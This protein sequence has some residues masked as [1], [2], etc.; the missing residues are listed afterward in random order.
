M[1]FV[2]L[3]SFLRDFY[4]ISNSSLKFKK[5]RHHDIEYLFPFIKK[6]PINIVTMEEIAKGNIIAVYDKNNNIVYYYN[7]HLKDINNN[8]FDDVT[9][10]DEEK[11]TLE[12]DISN[13]SKEELLKLRTK[14]RK[15]GLR[16]EAIK[17]TRQIR[18]IK[19]DEPREYYKRK[20]K[21]KI[22][23]NYYDKY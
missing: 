16:E 18:K 5:L 3:I 6:C 23:E 4:G 10:E 19:E 9:D 12:I 17:I 20:E 11:L 8:I 21:I 14:L 15:N 22:K 2:D 7:P 1:E 13:L